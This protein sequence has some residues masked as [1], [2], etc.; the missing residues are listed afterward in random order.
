[1]E[2]VPDP[3]GAEQTYI[4]EEEINQALAK[5]KRKG[6][7]EYEE[8]DQE[9]T[10]QPAANLQDMFDNMQISVVG[11]K[12]DEEVKSLAESENSEYSEYDE[13]EHFKED[14][15][16]ISQK[17]EKHTTLE[18]RDAEDMDFPDEVDTPV[19]EARKRFQKYRGIRSLKN[20]DWDPYENLPVEYSK[21]FRF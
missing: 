20:C 7:M 15:N 14:L 8:M 4:S 18:E 17:H 21:I 1:M 2:Q 6:S 10:G 16:K 5:S 9:M 19:K 13:D 3:F 12:D 11:G